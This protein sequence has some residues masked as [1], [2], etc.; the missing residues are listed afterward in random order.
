MQS[1]IE[2]ERIILDQGNPGGRDGE[3]FMAWRT[4]SMEYNQDCSIAAH[5]ICKYKQEIK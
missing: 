3:N 4:S 1:E 2:V 5:F